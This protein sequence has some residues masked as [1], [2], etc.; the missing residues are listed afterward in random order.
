MTLNSWKVPGPKSTNMLSL[1]TTP[2]TIASAV[3]A[4]RPGLVSLENPS[5][6]IA[7]VTAKSG[8][9]CPKP[10]LAIR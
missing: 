10:Y 1:S 8:A 6:E 4:T 2:I 3:V 7:T 9:G 5:D